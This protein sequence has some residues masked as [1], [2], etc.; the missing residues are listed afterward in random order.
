MDVLWSRERRGGQGGDEAKNDS[1]F[2]GF[3]TIATKPKPP[4]E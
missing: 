4:N 3:R 2:H 1:L